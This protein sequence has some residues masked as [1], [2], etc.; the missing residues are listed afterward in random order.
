MQNLSKKV[1][2]ALASIKHVIKRNGEEVDFDITKI[3]SAIFKAA[4]SVGGSDHKLS[5]DLALKVVGLLHK[6]GKETPTVDH[7][8]D[9]VEKILIEEGHAKTAKAF[10]LFRHM[11]NE[12]REKRELITGG[13]DTNDNLLFSNE[14][15]KILQRRYLLKN[16][17]GAP[18]ETPRMMLQRVAKNIASADSDYNSTEEQI[19]EIETQFFQMMAELRFLPNS[20]TLMNAGTKTQQLSSCFVL[21]I[22]DTM[23]G[24]F[25]TLKDAALIHQRG[26]GTGFSFSRL[27]KKGA[28]VGKNVGV[29]AGPVSFMKVYDKA[30]ESI[31]Q[32]GVRPGANMAVLRVDH[33]DIIRFIEAKRSTM[34]LKNFNISVG[35]TDNFMRA[36]EADREYYITSPH[37]KK[38]VGK[39]R[40]KDVFAMITQNAWKTGD[41]GLIFIDEINR[42]HPAKHLGEIET[43][44]QC[45][46]APLLPYEGIALGSINL[47]KFIDE[48]NLTV[49]WNKLEETV[50]LAVHFMDNVIDMNSYPHPKIKEQTMK[51]RKFGLGIMG[52]ADLLTRLHLKYDSEEALALA[53]DLMSFIKQ[54]AYQKSQQL[55]EWKGICPAWEGSEHQKS[56]R[57][58]RNMTCHSIS[59]T[60]TISILAGSSSG[61]EPLFA[62][63]YNRTLLGDSELIYLN[64]HFEN[65]AKNKGFYNS[66]LIRKITQTGSIQGLKEIPKWVRDIYVTAQDIA[67]E[68]HVRM[69]ATLQKNVDNSISKTINFPHTAA[70]KDVENAYVLAWKAKCKGITIYRDG[71]YEEQVINIGG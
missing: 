51:T 23:E 10:I 48:I 69:Q 35:V 16:D 54:T 46:E 26:S 58:M 49:Q 19:Q 38:Y 45:G 24:I 4:E 66:E 43:T 21:P 39:L 31:K 40:A 56:D 67:P 17:Q 61:C 15:L 55:A 53:D 14:A 30:L 12:R 71:S 22:E 70:I 50:K 44:N 13:K 3:T 36:V 11:K 42:K 7:V 27:R 68:W 29:A 34:A 18:V 8:Q 1:E 28:P 5:H 41:P 32:G 65:L 59:P 2:P 20:P 6:Y 52:L 60:G 33:P 25:S 37:T 63:A 57:K 47:N 64:Q 62:L 9:M